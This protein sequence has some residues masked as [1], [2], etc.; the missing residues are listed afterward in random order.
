MTAF[1]ANILLALAWMALTG[2]FGAS[3][4][5][6]GFLFGFCVIWVGRRDR[7]SAAYRQRL[8]AVAGFIVFFVKELVMANL[9]VAH[10]VLTP[11][12]YMTP[13]IVAVPLDLESDLQITLLSNLL[14]LTP[15]TL[16][17]NLSADRRT[18]YVHAMYIDDPA[19]M[20]REIKD[21]FE[22][23]IREVIQ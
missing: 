20:V 19:Q 13:G 11:R 18:L 14:T 16:S 15:G 21:G 17:L 1:L 5:F 8:L 6:T 3:G 4:F 7:A 10:D 2:S 23:R 12:D 22:R 9:R